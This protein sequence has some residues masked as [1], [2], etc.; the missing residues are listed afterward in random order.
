MAVVLVEGIRDAQLRCDSASISTASSRIVDATNFPP[1]LN[2]LPQRERIKKQ[3]R[4]ASGV[5][6][7]LAKASRPNRWSRILNHR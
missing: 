4:T 7:L 5:T 3:L 1:P 2:F 6:A